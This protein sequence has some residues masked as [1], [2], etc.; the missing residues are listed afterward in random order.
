MGWGHLGVVPLLIIADGT[1][2]SVH[3]IEVGLLSLITMERGPTGS[4]ARKTNRRKLNESKSGVG[5]GKVDG[6]LMLGGID[7]PLFFFSLLL[8]AGEAV[9]RIATD[10]GVR[11]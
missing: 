11:A 1:D 3:G 4:I 5:A 10:G 9:Q 8:R 6:R 2:Q 7:R